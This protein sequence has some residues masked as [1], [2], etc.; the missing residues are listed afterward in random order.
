MHPIFTRVVIPGAV[1]LSGLSCA[2]ALSMLRPS[3]ESKAPEAN[4]SPV[5]VVTAAPASLPAS[6]QA[7]GTV[8]ADAQVSLAPQVSGAVVFVDPRLRPGGVFARGDTLYRIDSR[9]Y[10][11]QLAADQARLAQARLELALE[12]KRQL[13]SQREW[14]L[15]GDANAEDELALRKPHLEAVRANVRSAEAAVQRSELNVRRTS[16][17]APFNGVVSTE[18]IDL[19]QVVSAASPGVVLV[20]T[21]SARVLVSVPVDRLENIDIP[22]FNSGSGSMVRVAGH[23]GEV[24]GVSGALDP[25]TRTATLAITVSNPRSGTTPLLPGSYVTAVITGRE[26]ANAVPLPR[27][28]V[29]TDNTV[30]LVQDGTLVKRPVEVGWRAKSEAYVV[31]GLSQGDTVVTTPPALPVEGMPVQPIES[32]AS[33]EEG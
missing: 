16:V 8:E 32:T 26:I 19:G 11:A 2:G 29:S 24:T 13:T 25:Q 30:W 12:E 15:L 14:E 22:G 20:G 27:K 10:E 23:D 17:R 21:D 31:N 6:I 5:E 9:D 7:N 3:A 33:A 1:V 18:T 28:A 4:V